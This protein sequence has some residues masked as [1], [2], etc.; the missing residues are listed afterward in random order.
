M[1]MAPPEPLHPS[2]GLH[3]VWHRGVLFLMSQNWIWGSEAEVH[4][5]L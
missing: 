5:H 2:L 4:W 1:G 3:V